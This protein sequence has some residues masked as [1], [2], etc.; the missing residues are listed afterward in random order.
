MMASTTVGK[1]RGVCI[2]LALLMW[3]ALILPSTTQAATPREI[4][5]VGP[6][7]VD[8]CA[9]RGLE[10]RRLRRDRSGSGRSSEDRQ[11]S[12]GSRCCRRQLA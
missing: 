6:E 8:N 5:L 4:V 2:I 7:Q 11:A 12:Q 3:A 1:G 10:E 9:L